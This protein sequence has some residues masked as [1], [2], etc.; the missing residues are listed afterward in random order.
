[1]SAAIHALGS[2]WLCW[3]TRDELVC[4]VSY[5]YQTNINHQ[6]LKFLEAVSMKNNSRGGLKPL[7]EAEASLIL[8]NYN[9]ALHGTL[10]LD[11]QLC[12]G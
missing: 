12:V 4:Y 5:S 1:M 10:F 2:E 8:F 9:A 11:D 6:A 3:G 7:D